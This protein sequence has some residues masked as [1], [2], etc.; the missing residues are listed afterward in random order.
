[1]LILNTADV[2]LPTAPKFTPTEKTQLSRLQRRKNVGDGAPVQRGTAVLQPLT[3][4]ERFQLEVLE[5][6]KAADVT[7]SYSSIEFP[8]GAFGKAGCLWEVPE[9]VGRLLLAQAPAFLEEVDRRDPRLA[10]LRVRK[11]GHLPS[12]FELAYGAK[13]IR[14]LMSLPSANDEQVAGFAPINIRDGQP[15]DPVPLPGVRASALGGFIDEEVS[16]GEREADI[17]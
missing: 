9:N 13:N 7:P 15:H 11:Y 1:M 16:E 3:A 14:E 8:F 17:L 10:G 12:T 5:A 4:E 6:R 2:A